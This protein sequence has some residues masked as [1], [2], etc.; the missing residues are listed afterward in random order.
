MSPT[1]KPGRETVMEEPH[2]A[3]DVRNTFVALFVRGVDRLAEIQKHTIDIAVQQNTDLVDAYKKLGQKIPGAARL[4][5][6]EV[7]NA[8]FDRFAEAQKNAIELAVEQSHAWIDAYKDRASVTNKAT[9]TAVNLTSQAM[10]RSV[11]AQKKV[12]ENAAVQTK[13]AVEAARQQMGFTGAPVEAAVS[14]FHRGMDT[15]VEAQ[16]EMLD[17]VAR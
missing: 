13:A 9:E 10:E 12:L 6:L 2:E 8:A 17:L 3:V 11:A 5:M 7:A 16:K 14:S 15:F 4:P 1:P